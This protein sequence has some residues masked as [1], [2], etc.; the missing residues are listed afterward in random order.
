MDELTAL[1][2]GGAAQIPYGTAAFQEQ[3]DPTAV[4]LTYRNFGDIDLTGAD[5]ALT[6]YLNQNWTVGGRYSYVSD[7]FFPKSDT[8]PHDIALKR[9]ESQS[10]R[11]Y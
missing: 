6:Y 1:Y 4:T 2:T 11:A 7:D 10:R 3:T 8:Q 5:L 9:S